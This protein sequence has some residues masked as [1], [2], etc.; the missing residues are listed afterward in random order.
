MCLLLRL[1]SI[2][3]E[4]TLDVHIGIDRVI[5]VTIIMI[6]II[7]SGRGLIINKKFAHKTVKKSIQYKKKF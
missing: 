7:T 2:F 5:I 4:T 1:S 3:V 6:I